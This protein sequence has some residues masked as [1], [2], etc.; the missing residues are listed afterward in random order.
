MT[1]HIIEVS[2]CDDYTAVPMEV[3]DVE[4]A[5]IK[6]LVDMVNAACTYG[7]KPFI[8]V[9]PVRRYT[10]DKVVADY[11]EAITEKREKEKGN[12]K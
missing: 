6:K 3:T 9:D 11:Q 2:V 8:E 4:L 1:K 10:W 5:A 7:C 12:Q